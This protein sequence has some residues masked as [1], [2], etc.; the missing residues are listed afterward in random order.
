MRAIAAAVLFFEAVVVMLAIPVAVTVSY[1]DPEVA[2][3][4]GLALM[5]LAL[6]TA[7]LLGRPFGYPMGWAVQILVLL[8]GV[9]VPAMFVVGGLFVVLWGAALHFGRKGEAVRASW[10]QPGADPDA[11]TA[12]PSNASS[13]AD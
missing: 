6:V 8:S 1:V 9:V 2:I 5:V 11:P 12:G 3:P 4:V 13:T 7:G 10:P